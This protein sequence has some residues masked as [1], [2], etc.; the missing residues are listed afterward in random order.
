MKTI[1]Y[2]GAPAGFLARLSLALRCV[3]IK[4]SLKVIERKEE[5]YSLCTMN[6]VEFNA[7]GAVIKEVYLQ[8]AGLQS[9]SPAHARPP[10]TSEAICSQ[11]FPKC[12]FL[13]GISLLCETGRSSNRAQLSDQCRDAQLCGCIL[14]PKPICLPLCRPHVPYPSTS[15]PKTNKKARGKKLSAKFQISFSLS[16]VLNSCVECAD[17]K[18]KHFP[19]RAAAA[20]CS[21]LTG[22]LKVLFALLLKEPFLPFRLTFIYFFIFSCKV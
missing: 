12:L 14:N 13:P 5:A 4:A 2:T 22:P 16:L 18:G 9:P 3:E 11:R 7:E 17:F 10:L 21:D 19:S 8:L 1:H 15:H 6:P 20:T